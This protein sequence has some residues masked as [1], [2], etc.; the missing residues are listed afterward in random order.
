[1][2]SASPMEL[3]LAFIGLGNVARAFARMIDDRRDQLSDGYGLKLR[4]TAIATGSHGCVLSDGDIDLR[5]AAACVERGEPLTGLPGVAAISD[6]SGLIDRCEADVVFETTPLNP[7]DGEPAATYI[8]NAL[9]RGMNVVTANKGPVAFAYRRLKAL[10]ERKRVS[11]RFEGTVM[12]GAPVFNLVEYCLP[13]ARVIR[14]SGVLNSTT[15]LILAGMESGRTFDECLDEARRLGIAE[16][17]ADYDIDGWDAAAKAI[18]LANVLM[19]ADLRPNDVDRAGI[20]DLD[21]RETQA[22]AAAGRPLRLIARA[23]GSGDGAKIVVGPERVAAASPLGSVRGTSNVL[24]IET[25]LM[26]E[27]VIFETNPGIEQ[28]AYAL[29]SDL[30]RVHEEAKSRR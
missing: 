8:L 18:V 15:N 10:A 4:T 24:I 16:T 21:S 7:T 26:G 1:V 25:D 27:L 20:R 23:E 17:N 28:T 22:A 19:G 11:F 29:L 14:F 3:R 2:T 9:G 12:D 6:T 30:I 13:V 5:A